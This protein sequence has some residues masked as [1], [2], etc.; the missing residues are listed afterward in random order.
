[1]KLS[2]RNASLV[3]HQ[4]HVMEPS[5]EVVLGRTAN[6]VIWKAVDNDAIS[7]VA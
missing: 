6:D 1:M 4:Q 3:R 5:L 7:T 2:P